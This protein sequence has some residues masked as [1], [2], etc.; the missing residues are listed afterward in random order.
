MCMKAGTAQRGPEPQWA[1]WCMRAIGAE[2]DAVYDRFNRSWVV[3]LI[4]GPGQ[5][6]RVAALVRILHATF[7]RGI[8]SVVFQVSQQLTCS[9]DNNSNHITLRD[10]F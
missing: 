1:L 6:T 5:W 3:L 4:L 10:R 2:K 7:A 9:P 8:P